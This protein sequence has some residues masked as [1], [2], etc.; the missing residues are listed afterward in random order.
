MSNGS[1]G[2]PYKTINLSG[3]IPDQDS[4]FGTLS[5]PALDLQNGTPDGFALVNGST[6]IQFLSYEGA[7]TAVG[8]H[9]LHLHL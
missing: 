7:F 5:F 6:V 3:S 8:S 9:A 4:G 1:G 2:A